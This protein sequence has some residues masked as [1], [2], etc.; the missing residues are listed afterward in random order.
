MS[1]VDRQTFIKLYQPNFDLK[2]DFENLAALINNLDCIISPTSAV[3]AFA[4]SCGVPT[5]SYYSY[6]TDRA[7]CD[8][9]GRKWYRNAWLRNNKIFIYDKTNKIQMLNLVS[10]EINACLS[11]AS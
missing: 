1:K 7:L 9:E 3:M 5:I 6:I 2:N 8:A 10:G 4:A 11:N